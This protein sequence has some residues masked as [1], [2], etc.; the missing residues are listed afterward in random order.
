MARARTGEAPSGEG[1]LYGG[2]HNIVG[3]VA[4][5][6]LASDTGVAHPDGKLPAMARHELD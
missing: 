5:E 3:G 2:H 1:L 4:L 6:G